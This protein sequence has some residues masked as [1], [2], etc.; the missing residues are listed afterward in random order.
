MAF[1]EAPR[2]PLVTGPDGLPHCSACTDEAPCRYHRA[3][4]TTALGQLKTANRLARLGDVRYIIRAKEE[5]ET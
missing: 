2:P 3:Q 4:I 5:D 1:S